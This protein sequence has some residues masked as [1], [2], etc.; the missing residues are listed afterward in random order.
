M[1]G[2]KLRIKIKEIKLSH[3]AQHHKIKE[4]LMDLVS[5]LEEVFGGEGEKKSSYA[6]EEVG[7]VIFI[8]E[9][10]KIES[11]PEPEPVPAWKQLLEEK[12]ENK[13]S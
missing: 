9:K 5:A 6:A 4:V 3:R 11:K 13:P 8:D 12:D 2:K 7:T 10:E 1:D